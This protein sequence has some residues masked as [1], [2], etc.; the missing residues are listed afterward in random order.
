MQ[1]RKQQIKYML[2]DCV[3]SMIAWCLF[4]FYRRYFVDSKVYDD[5]IS[6]FVEWKFYA[7]LIIIPLFW[8]FIFYI[9]GFYENMKH[10]SRFLDFFMTISSVIVGSLILFFGVVLNDAVH[11]YKHYYLILI[12]L[13]LL[14]FVFV[15]IFRLYNSN[16]RIKDFSRGIS[17]FRTLIIGD[18]AEGVVEAANIPRQM[19]N[20]FIGVVLRNNR[21]KGQIVNGFT[22][23][24]SYDEL[25]EVLLDNAIEEVVLGLKQTE[26]FD[27]QKLLTILYRRNIRV[28][29]IPDVYEKII[30]S[31]KMQPIYGCNLMEISHEI[32]S[33]F[34]MRLK[35]LMDVAIASIMLVLLLPI[36]LYI[37]LRIIMDSKGSPIYRQVRV[38][39]NGQPFTIYKFRSMIVSAEAETPMLT[40]VDDERITKYGRYLRKYRIDELPQ[41]WNVLKGDMS[42][43]GPRP[44]R[45]FFIDRMV[46]ATPDYFFLQKV[47]PGI[48]SLGMVKFG[49]A[50]CVEKMLKRFKYDLIYVENMSLMLDIKILYY[51]LFVIITG[52]GV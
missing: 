35:R 51:T 7:E 11:T 31:A 39:K 50:D 38:G 1:R 44:E 45:Q 46:A 23:L 28:K 52:K 2:T 13:I 33:P 32:M 36:S 49:Y 17:G 19:G 3:M 29:V 18:I 21:A 14:E 26:V 40:C 24:G 12:I 42:I 20:I 30:G 48:T 37:M 9:S 8:L 41:F 47:R 15:Y 25:N 34:E 27:I 43:V 4:Y 22:C 5:I 6:P 10:R 16:R